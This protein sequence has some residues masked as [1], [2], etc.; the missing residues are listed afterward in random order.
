MKAWANRVEN[1]EHADALGYLYSVLLESFEHLVYPQLKKWN[2]DASPWKRRLSIVP[3]IYYATPTRKA[4]PAQRILPLV[5]NLLSDRDPYVQKAVGWTLR[6]C[7]TLYPEKT[8]AFLK[9]H[10]RDLV[11]IS[12]SYA[13]ERLS[14]SQK[15]ALKKMRK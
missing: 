13:T 7:E 8:F 6:E 12:F 4:P 11:P 5:E 2:K 3:L 14:P 1:W 10:I 9:K 15:I